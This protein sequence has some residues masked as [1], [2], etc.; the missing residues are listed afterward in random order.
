MSPE[1]VLH[2]AR[3]RVLFPYHNARRVNEEFPRTTSS[4]SCAT[5]CLPELLKGLFGVKGY[6]LK[7]LFILS[8]S[9]DAL[10]RLPS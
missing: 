4:K 2:L 9:S 7:S 1:G 10:C 5:E 8:L 3:P 6:Y